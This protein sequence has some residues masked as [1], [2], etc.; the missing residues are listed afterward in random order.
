MTEYNASIR[1]VPMP[2]RIKRLRVSP[3]GFPT[4]WFV[5]W[6]GDVPD[7]RVIGRGKVEAAY[8]GKL[9]WVCGNPLGRT[10]GFVIG[11]MCVVNRVSSEPP[12]HRECGVY[13]ALACPFLA[14]PRMRRNEKDMPEHREMPGLGLKR[15]PGAGAVWLTRSYRPF[16][17]KHYNAGTLFEI[18]EPTEVLWFAQGRTATRD[19]VDA[20]I[21]SGLPAL[22][23]Q[24]DNDPVPGAHAALAQQVQKAQAYLPA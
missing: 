10:F 8:K 9:C 3:Q 21:A 18:G 11:P 7:F 17:A 19:E 23:E 13:A 22:Q 1:A 2:D 4:P 15:N 5:H 16:R 6:D 24:A 12:S 20:S 14:N